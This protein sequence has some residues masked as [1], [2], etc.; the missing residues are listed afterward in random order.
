MSVLFCLKMHMSPPSS[1]AAHVSTRRQ[2]SQTLPPSRAVWP[3]RGSSGA[4][5]VR[6]PWQCTRRIRG[7]R[8]ADPMEGTPSPRWA[9]QLVEHSNLLALRLWENSNVVAFCKFSDTWVVRLT[10]LWCSK[11]YS[12]LEMVGTLSRTKHWNPTQNMDL[13]NF[14]RLPPRP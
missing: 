1:R 4:L 11:N 2:R 3:S 10:D 14:S 5:R 7:T 12:G 9:Q 8:R 6:D 13:Y